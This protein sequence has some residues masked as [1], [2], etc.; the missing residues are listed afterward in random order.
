MRSLLIRCY[1]A[2]WRERYGDEFLAILEERPLGPYDVADILLGA[3]DARLRS[4]RERAA[5]PHER[6]LPM[7]LR[8]GGIAAIIGAVILGST[9]VAT[10]TGTFPFGAPALV[11]MCVIGMVA[12][13][14]ALIVLSAFQAREHPGLVWTGFGL[15]AIGAVGF[16]VG[17]LTMIGVVE[18][19]V[20]GGGLPE[21]LGMLALAAGGMTAVVGLAPVWIANFPC[22]VRSRAGAVLLAIGPALMAVA[23]VVALSIAWD[24]GGVV[25]IGALASFVTGWVVLGIAA[26][27]HDRL[28]TMRGS[29]A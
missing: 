24:L 1:P 29:A 20:S 25:M 12:L 6:G 26:I 11:A 10:L 14:V 2:R 23:W 19:S 4:R 5:R 17:L 21:A 13:I 27:R 22:P 3:V 9:L 28:T 8:I 16:V 7:S 18:G 15:S